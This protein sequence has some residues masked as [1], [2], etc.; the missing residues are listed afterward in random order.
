[1]IMTKKNF[2]NN[3][4]DFVNLDLPS[5]TLWATANVGASEP[6]DFGLYFQWGDTKGYSS[7]QVGESKGKKYFGWDGYKWDINKGKYATK[8]T[9]L[10]LEDDAANHYMGGDWHI[11]TPTQIRELM[12]NTR[13]QWVTLNGVKG[14]KLASKHDRTKSIF[15]PAAGTWVPQDD[16]PICCGRE[17][18]LW[19]S[20]LDEVP[21]YY[22]HYLFFYSRYARLDCANLNAGFSVRGVIG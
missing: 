13:S 20:M 10:K 1:M 17:G 12:D 19:S 4:Y 3:G 2:N 8:G 11:P 14:M 18:Y 16:S 22:G 7:N 15:I 9:T 6:T 21:V 5:G